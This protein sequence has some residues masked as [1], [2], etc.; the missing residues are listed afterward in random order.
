MGKR[1][2]NNKHKTV[3]VI[4]VRPILA[5]LLILISVYTI[6]MR[7]NVLSYLKTNAIAVFEEQ[8]SGRK[9]SVSNDMVNRWSEISG[10][11]D[12]IVRN[13]EQIVRDQGADISDI[14][15][16]AVLNQRILDGLMDDIIGTLRACGGTEMFLVLDGQAVVSD[17]MDNMK[18]GVYLRN[19][20][21][22]FYT[23]DNQDL[24]FE[25]GVPSIS[26]NWKISLDSYWTVGFDFTDETDKDN[27][28]YIKPFHAALASENKDFRNFGCW[29][30][31]HPVNKLDRGVLSYSIPLITSDGSVVGVMGVGVGEEYFSNTIN[32]R[33]LGEGANG[34][35]FLAKTTDGK[36]FE[37]VIFNGAGY[38]KNSF[39]A[40]RVE[41]SE[42]KEDG[43]RY[44]YLEG[45]TKSRTCASVQYLQLYNN[46]TPFEQEQWA[47]VGIQPRERLLAAYDSAQIM[48]IGLALGGTMI[49]V[50]GIFF[51]SRLVSKPLRRLMEDLRKS[52]TDKPIHLHR[53]NVE[54]I[55]ELI[56]AIESLSA[57]VAESSSKI[58][59]I[60]QM[61]ESGIGVYEYRKKDQTVF[62]SRSMYEIFEWNPIVDTNEYIDS[63]DF[64]RR[65]RVMEEKRVSGEENLYELKMQ[66]GSAKWIR[67]N[68][69]DD[70]ESIIGVVRDVTASVLKQ[71][72]IE[73]ER[74]YDTLTNLYN[75]RAFNEYAL[76]L[77]RKPESVKKVGA[78]VMWDMDNLKFVN[79]M[80]G[81]HMGDLYIIALANCFIKYQ[82]TRVLSARRSGDEFYT[83]FYGFENQEQVKEVLDHIWGEIQKSEIILPDGRPYKIRVSAGI[84]WYP[85]NSTDFME[86]LSYAD[87]AM[88]TVKHSRKGDIGSFDPAAYREDWYLTQGQ[89]DFNSLVDNRL[90]R[91]AAQPIVAVRD[92]SIYGYEMLMRSKM[93]SFQTP[94]DIL[95]MAHAQSRLYDIEVMT[96]FEALKSYSQLVE[97]GF[98]DGDS[99]VFINSIASQLLR[100]DMLEVLQ[101]NFAPYLESVVCEFTEEEHGS[102]QITQDKLLMV[103]SWNAK[104]A[105]DDYGCGYNSESVL[106]EVQPDIVKID[107]GIIRGINV[108]EDRKHLV[109]NLI[110]YA[111]KRNIKVLGEGVETLEE[112]RTLIHLGVDL[113]Q[114]Y[115]IA[116][117]TYE[118]APPAD[119][120]IQEIVSCYQ[121]KEN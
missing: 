96:W 84:A 42:S 30:F 27:C 44:L 94:A 16:D 112:L 1:H 115:Y 103:H 81:H 36:Y 41:I 26:K 51:T 118:G 120:V 48:L 19:N 2:E 116:K 121:E 70:T 76:D 35:Y 50:S 3:F 95:R 69:V 54:E 49:G 100:E 24:L 83:M 80:Y 68:S 90:V 18:A 45:E 66:D 11:A 71:R 37:P 93:N 34:A 20:N 108:D 60:I 40:H 14:H 9:L 57:R 104:V 4:L 28:Y 97:Y 46:N 55:D 21:P 74:D 17:G 79:D 75:L 53:L 6:V 110:I 52:D 89:G 88:Y 117:P 86:L 32:Y 59:K 106:L 101:K 13:L 102:S 38:N 91:Y 99:K 78:L 119:T 23:N 77:S 63:S 15:T 12:K 25:R 107:M 105:I 87:F 82:S 113:L 98:I 7:Q 5:I 114:G 62:C 73:Y 33:E 72:Q 67:L 92:G 47:L 58:S 109:K 8:V 22:E 10:G 65:M 43:L 29:C 56:Y 39:L 61:T 111:H 85:E 64:K 31:G